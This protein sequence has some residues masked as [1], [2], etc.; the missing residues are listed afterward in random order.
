LQEGK[1]TLAA[2]ALSGD[3]FK[4]GNKLRL[5]DLVNLFKGGHV[6]SDDE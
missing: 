5:D 1:R 2:A 6:D 4:S 3:K